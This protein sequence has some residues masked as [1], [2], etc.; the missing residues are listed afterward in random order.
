M[1][2]GCVNHYLMQ[3][4][5]RF[6]SELEAGALVS[7]SEQRIRVRSLPIEALDQ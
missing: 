2:A 7:V 1:R 5:V 4:I 6:P 3:V